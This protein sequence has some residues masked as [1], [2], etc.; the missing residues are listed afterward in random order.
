MRPRGLSKVLLAGLVMLGTGAAS[1]DAV[2]EAERW[3]HEA[4]IARA[5]NFWHIAYQRYAQT[6][7][8]F[9]GT[10]HGNT[11]AKRA[12]QM[13][14]WGVAPDRSSASEDPAS[15]LTELFDFLTW[16]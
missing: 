10:P 1:S 13:R 15:W 9:P 6:A 3:Q 11:G 5:G 8:T 12:N 4:D 14:H 7:E 16:P 2:R